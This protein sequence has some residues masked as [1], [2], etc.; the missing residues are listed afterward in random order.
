MRKGYKRERE[1]NNFGYIELPVITI[2][3]RLWLYGKIRTVKC[4]LI[5]FLP[6]WLGVCLAPLGARKHTPS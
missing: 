2:C 1:A 4:P 5:H 6:N 3:T